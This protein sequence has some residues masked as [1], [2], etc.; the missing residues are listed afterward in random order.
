[1][2]FLRLFVALFG[3][4]FLA[5]IPS[6]AAR[7]ATVVI[8]SGELRGE[9]VDGVVRFLG[10]PYAAPP[11]GDLRWTA[12]HPV[13]AWTGRRDAIV[14]APGC[15]QP[16]T[17]DGFGPW[18][19]EYVTPPPVSED[20]LY[21]NVWM[22]ERAA[23]KPLPILVWIHGGAFM[24]GSNS[25]PIYD[26]SE[27]AKMG[28]IVISINYRLGVFGFAGFRELAGEAGGGA[29][30]GLQD[31]VAS[32]RWVQ[33]NAAAF[34]GD[35]GQ[36]TIAGQSAG[37]MAVHMLLVSPASEGLFARAIAQSGLIET[38]LPTRDDGFRRGDDLASRVGA[39]S[40]S[41]LRR[42]PAEQVMGLL[43]K[44]PLEGTMQIGGTSLLGPVVDGRILPDQVATLEASG[45]RKAVP[46]MIGLN[47]DEGVLNPDYFKTT[48]EALVA[49]LRGA[50]GEQQAERML[51]GEAI[52]S[53]VAAIAATRKLTRLYGLASVIDWAKGHRAPLFA[54][55][56]THSE[57][58]PGSDMFGAFHSAE[59]PYVFN[60][61]G[62][63]PW[64]NFTD[65]DLLIA[66]NMSAYWANFVKSSD[67]N[68]ADL[69]HWQRFDRAKPV[70]MELGGKFS[71]YHPENGKLDLLLDWMSHGLGRSIFG[72]SSFPATQGESGK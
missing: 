64:R 6:A 58:G 69:P 61:L 72:A 16:V 4:A 26:G 8:E 40:V 13:R 25:V 12:P 22:P 67:P 65:E 23:A 5:Q 35:P 10:V 7:D 47:A 34:G 27:L 71:T 51:A 53:D 39:S 28:V 9:V 31:I 2:Q 14:Q 43:A 41:A 20:C 59:I 66:H 19:K 56:Y 11:I 18:T 52:D 38:P 42:L 55:Y 15:F 49:Q 62:A 29:N 48:P 54:Y 46:V 70:V 60:S 63:S 21:A 30:F 36:V 1:M 33:R 17:P 45:K 3:A 50:V 44:G 37:A 57:P 32:L 24:S 68:G